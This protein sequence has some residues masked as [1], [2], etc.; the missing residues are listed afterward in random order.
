MFAA[1][2]I[3]TILGGALPVAAFLWAWKITRRRSHE[4]DGWIAR[5]LELSNRTIEERW[6][7]GQETNEILKWEGIPTSTNA[8]VATIRLLIQ[9]FI[10]Q[11]ALPDLGLP[12]IL[13]AAGFVCGFAGSLLSLY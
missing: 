7:P 12:I 5:T 4:I 2:L 6:A 3:L 8:D 13:G 10:V 11:E 9:K 1:E